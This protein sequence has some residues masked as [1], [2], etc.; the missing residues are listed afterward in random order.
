MDIRPTSSSPVDPR[1]PGRRS[2]RYERRRA[3]ILDIAVGLI[4]DKGVG[5]MTLQDVSQA[6][7][8][9]TTSVTY[10]YRYKEQLVAAVFEDTLH[11]LGEMVRASAAAATP[12]ERVRRYVQLF[13]EQFEK[14]LRGEDRPLAVLS[15]LRTLDEGLRR[16]LIAAYQDVFRDV[17]RLFGDD[18]TPERKRLLSARAQLLNEALFWAAIWLRRYP[19]RDF[20]NVRRR[21]LNLLE[22]GLAIPGSGWNLA[23]VDPDAGVPE[24][25]KRDFLRVA[26][27]LINDIGYKGA[28]VDR[29][30]REL[31]ITKGSF[32]HHLEAKD[33]L[34][35]ACYHYD[36][37]RLARLQDAI[38]ASGRPVAS[39]L[40]SALASTLTLQFDGSHPMLRTNAL[41]AMPTT[42]R[43][44]PLKRF[45]RLALWLSGLLV[46]GMTEG[47]IRIVDPMIAANV[48]ISTINSA[49]DLRGWAAK[50]SRLQ[51]IETYAGLLTNGLFGPA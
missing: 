13:F 16:Q 34:I 21:L 1:D 24:N 33:D 5:A 4:N 6:L 12:R 10:Y 17:R 41:N 28:S 51:A 29:I 42:V 47:S 46:D 49:Y 7:D 40:G 25:A 20:P 22:N 44:E 38:D 14:A 9:T 48:I 2:A 8:L 11:R 45:D 3:A 30:V 19:M 23:V 43:Q 37:H 15:E 32:Y 35:L 26:S 18:D 39:R 31:K 27:R 36:W 50:Q